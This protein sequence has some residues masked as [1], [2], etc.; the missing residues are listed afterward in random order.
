MIRHERTVKDRP[1][2]QAGGSGSSTQEFPPIVPKR[3]LGLAPVEEDGSFHIE[4]PPDV[5]VQIQALDADGLS[6]AT[7]GWIWVKPRE[8]RGCI[9]CHEDPELTPENRFVLAVR[10]PAVQLTLPA[11]KRRSVDFQRDILPI[12]AAKCAACHPGEKTKLDLR[13]ERRGRF[14]VAYESLLVTDRSSKARGGET[15][16]APAAVG[17]YVHPGQARTSPLAWRLMGRNTS[18]PWDAVGDVGRKITVCPPP[19]AEQLTEAERRAIFEWIDLGASW[20]GVPA[21]E[22]A[23]QEPPALAGG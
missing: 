12:V 7:C 4:L 1:V 9:G 14:N 8:W 13:S 20:A 2:P 5:P 17:R 11:E 22:L 6:L 21:Q 15:T 16:S 10:K 19:G 23:A 18:R 3:L